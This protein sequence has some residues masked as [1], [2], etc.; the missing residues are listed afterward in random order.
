LPGFT[1][2]LADPKIVYAPPAG[3][4]PVPYSRYPDGEGR[5][6]NYIP[7]IP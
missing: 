2:Q 4:T 3:T 1:S 7:V 6:R 5:G